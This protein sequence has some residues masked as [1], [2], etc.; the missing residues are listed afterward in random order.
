MSTDD[1]QLEHV[2]ARF[3]EYRVDHDTKFWFQGLLDQQLLI[4]RCDECGRWSH[5]PAPICPHCWS[6]Q[7]QRVA[8]VGRGH[9]RRW[10]RFHHHDPIRRQPVA[11]SMA[12]VTV[13]LD[14][15]EG[16]SLTLEFLAG[17][18]PHLDELVELRWV[19]VSG[20]PFPAFEPVSRP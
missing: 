15:C 13:D 20:H 3:D 2:V 1:G 5:P 10:T 8:V 14:D 11:E 12:M 16:V 19:D 17:R 9:V 4:E 18:D 6:S 7:R